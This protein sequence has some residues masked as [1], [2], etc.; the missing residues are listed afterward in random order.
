MTTVALMARGA[1]SPG[2]V[3]ALGV[4]KR[5]AKHGARATEPTPPAKLATTSFASVE[6][7]ADPIQRREPLAAHMI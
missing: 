2:G 4:N 6:N 7:E 1:R 3:T 5:R